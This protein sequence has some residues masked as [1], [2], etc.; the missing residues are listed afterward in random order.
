MYSEKISNSYLDQVQK[1]LPFELERFSIQKSRS[2]VDAVDELINKDLYQTASRRGIRAV[3]NIF[4]DGTLFK[5]QSHRATF[6]SEEVQNTIANERLIC[7]WDANYW[8][9]RYQLIKDVTGIYITYQALPAQKIW[10]RMRADLNEKHL[11][12]KFLDL[13]GRQ[14]GDTTDKQ[15]MVQHRIMFFPDTDAT[16]ASFKKEDTEAM[17]MKLIS[18]F[19][20]QPFWLKPEFER[21]TTGEG[22][23]FDNGSFL[24]LGYGTQEYIAKGQTPLVCHI[25]E[26]ASFLHPV[27]A[28]DNALFNAMHETEWILQFLEGTAEARD[29][30]FHKKVLEVIAGM[31]K[32]ITSWVFN[33]IP[34][35]FRRDLKPTEAYVKARIRAFNDFIPKPETLAMA[36]MAENY[37]K[38]WKYSREELGSNWKMPIEQLFW[39]Q[40][41]YEQAEKNDNLA[42]FLSQNPV[43]VDQAFQHAGKTL[44]KIQLIESY[45][46]KAHSKIPEIYKLKGDASEISTLYWPE[47]DEILPEREGGK[48]IKIRCD[49]NSGIPASEFELIQLRFNGW[50]NFDPTNKIIIWEHPKDGFKYGISSDTSDGLGRDVSDD[51]IINVTRVGTPEFKDKQVCE[52]ASPEVPLGSMWPF[53]LAIASYYSQFEGQQLIS[54]ECNKGYEFQNALIHRGW[55]NLFKRLDESSPY[56]D[57]SKIQKYGFW[58]DK[59]TR[60]ALIGHFHSFFIGKHYEIYSPMLL[61]EIRDLQKIRKPN[62]QL[63][64]ASDKIMGKKDNRVLAAAINLYS[65]HRNE[66][67]GHE[68]KSWEERKKFEQ[69]IVEIKSFSGFAWE[70]DFEDEIEVEDLGGWN[71][72]ELGSLD[73]EEDFA[74]GRLA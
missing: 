17:S 74:F 63:G 5:S 62:A 49:W 33:F 47:F 37:V 50:Q 42:A 8:Q 1:T 54:I 56:Q 15:G 27:S 58:T 38:S 32:G 25:S 44:Y 60:P 65:I 10:R 68:K 67:A 18:S 16:I 29:D 24:N 14:Q 35:F 72:D 34:W 21:F 73:S 11:P 20:R 71:A 53:G 28:L 4:D 13:K 61:R 66:I 40:L 41:E 7:K 22:Y 52:F 43:T 46:Q 12:I 3:R 6:F 55:W 69:N 51:A 31:E 26:I 30:W 57:E 59:A 64:F 45:E 2:F 19:E 9:D 48:T 36:R 39:Y 23:R 70:K